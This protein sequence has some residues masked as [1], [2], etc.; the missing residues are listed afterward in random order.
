MRVGAHETHTGA[1]LNMRQRR[2]RRTASHEG[3]AGGADLRA[4]VYNDRV[5]LAATSTG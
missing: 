3:K 4:L 2:E 5:N 1:E